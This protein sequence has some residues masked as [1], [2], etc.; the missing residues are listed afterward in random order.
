MKEKY[1]GID[2]LINNAAISTDP[3]DSR[4]LVEQAESIMRT[5]YWAVKEMCDTMLPLM[6][7]GARMVNVS[8][9]AGMLSLLDESDMKA[10]LRTAGKGLKVSY[11]VFPNF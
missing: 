5:N 10:K 3:K 9:G 11:Y 8:S 7:P 1:G 4:P 6:K 2:I